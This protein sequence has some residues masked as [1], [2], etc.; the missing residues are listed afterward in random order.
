MFEQLLMY[1]YVQGLSKFPQ[2]ERKLLLM[3]NKHSFSNHSIIFM[4]THSDL[5]PFQVVVWSFPSHT[6]I[7]S[8]LLTHSLSLSLSL[9]LLLRSLAQLSQVGVLSKAVGMGTYVDSQWG[10]AQFSLPSEVPCLCA[11]LPDKKSIVGQPDISFN[12]KCT[13]L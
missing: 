6:L 13:V 11:F 12:N 4:N 1:K 9:L 7:L 8:H 2:S 5:F 10:L 3:V